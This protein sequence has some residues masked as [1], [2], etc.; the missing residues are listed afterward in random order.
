MKIL[1]TIA[2]VVAVLVLV[3][4]ASAAAIDTTG[5][6][7]GSYQPDS[8]TPP[9]GQSTWALTVT[10]GDAE[11]GLAVTLTENDPSAGLATFLD[12]E[13]NN[14]GNGSI[15]MNLDIT[16]SN[17][18]TSPADT[19]YVFEAKVKVNSTAPGSGAA[20]R[21]QAVWSV[22]FKD[23]GGSG[24]SVRIG[25]YSDA[26]VL[27]NNGNG[28]LYGTS[29]THFGELDGFTVSTGTWYTFRVEKFDDAGT[30]K[31][32]VSVNGTQQDIIQ[33]DGSTASA[34]A[35]DDLGNDDASTVG[36]EF[37]TADAHAVDMEVDYVEFVPEPA[38]MV[39]LGLGG[40]GLLLRRR[41]S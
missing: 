29:G 5:S 23:E 11:N 27:L 17:L 22:G 13:D 34:Y 6:Y 30:M 37:R 10:D 12:E 16:D 31:V 18:D 19:T 36:F 40:V 33:T 7:D 39:L 21:N 3:G 4:Q 8:A 24:K 38:T 25:Q 14:N 2:G 20:N 26:I 41:R 28:R 1:A 15:V 32:K 35:Y 9:A